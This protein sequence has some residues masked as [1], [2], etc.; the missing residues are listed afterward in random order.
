MRTRIK[1][2]FWLSLGLVLFFATVQ[3]WYTRPS[4]TAG[5]FIASLSKCRYEEAQALLATPS[6]IE[7][8]ENGELVLTNRAG[9]TTTV[10][11]GNL[12]FHFLKEDEPARD[13]LAWPTRNDDFKMI[14]LGES[15]GW[16]LR[17][18]PFR[19]YLRADGGEVHIERVEKVE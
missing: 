17:N 8:A 12:P 3:L 15:E 19:L 7:L 5:S 4:R 10:P 1:R 18:P 14:A 13:S 11:A 6:S 16:I 2:L 9:D